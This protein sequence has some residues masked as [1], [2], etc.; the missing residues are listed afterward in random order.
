MIKNNRIIKRKLKKKTIVLL[1]VI[2]LILILFIHSCSHVPSKPV[3]TKQGDNDWDDKTVVSVEEDSKP[4]NEILNYEYCI[5]EEENDECKWKKTATKN[6]ELAND[7]VYYV[8]FRAVTKANK[9]GKSSDVSTIKID[10][11]APTISEIKGSVDGDS[12][13]IEVV[14]SDEGSGINKYY[15]KI[16]DGD[17]TSSSN[18]THTFEDLDM[19]EDYILDIKVVDKADNEKNVIINLDD[20]INDLT[21]EEENN[22]EELP[23]ISLSDIPAIIVVGD[24]YSLP[25]SYDFG[26]VGG[27]VTCTVNDE[28]ITDTKELGLGKHEVACVAK[29]NSGVKVIETKNIEVRLSENYSDNEWDGWILLELDYPANSTNWKWRIGRE[30]EARIG[31]D[32]TSW[33]DYTGP[34][35]I[36]ETDKDN[37]Y[38]KYDMD[39]EVIDTP[40]DKL[41]IDIQPTDSILK[42]GQKTEVKIVYEEDADSIEYRID[43]GEWTDYTKPFK[44]GPN[45]LISARVSKTINGKLITSYDYFYIRLDD[46]NDEISIPT[47]EDKLAGPDIL[48]STRELVDKVTV[49]IDAGDDVR[50][51]YYKIDNGD[52]QEF[53]DSFVV[54]DNVTIYAYYI[55]E[56]DGRT[57]STSTL[58]V[59]NIVLEDM[60]YVKINVEKDGDIRIITVS[61]VDCDNVEYSFDGKIYFEYTGAFEITTN[62]RVYVKGTNEKGET[63]EYVDITDIDNNP[64]TP[65]YEDLKVKI[66]VTPDSNTTGLLNEVEVTISYDD[67]ATE[68]YYSIDG[69]GVIEYTGPFVIN[70]NSIIKA[71]AKSSNGY[72]EDKFEINYM[73]EGITEPKISVDIEEDAAYAVIVSINYDTLSHIKKYKLNDGDWID[74]SGKITIL[75]NNTTITAY[76]ENSLGDFAT[77]TYTITNI[78]AKNNFGVEDEGEYFI[79]SI[80]YPESSDEDSRQ[81]KWGKNGTWKNYDKN[82]K[83]LLVKKDYKDTLIKNN[84]VKIT[85]ENGNE[86]VYK[87]HYYVVDKFDK[88]YMKDL[89][90]RMLVTNNILDTMD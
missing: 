28:K 54:D 90:I 59:D 67:N 19:D 73:Y 62:R 74:Y 53:T 84:E 60:P 36:R 13:K 17:Y 87:D 68:V 40:D 55:T 47:I 27:T 78:V 70:H 69:N 45:T 35:T 49:S 65:V 50:M 2:I 71:Y 25:T 20:I 51:I 64:S 81:Y 3:I 82:L 38:I 32:A 11:T 75:D 80:D 58:T 72:G 52:W 8:K 18:N 85:D 89:Y 48:L 30:G 43:D 16:D 1:F 15:Y 6:V 23:A 10:N 83:I 41:V 56:S 63:I 34:I 77:S 29:S 88:T 57:S 12:V 42:E 4:V 9:F 46:E 66:N 7:G 5:G 76:N 86:V 44:V 39:D 14:A 24:S 61:S 37:V 33:Q 21:D 31:D 22:T 26:T 79:L